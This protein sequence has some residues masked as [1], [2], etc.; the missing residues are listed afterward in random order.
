MTTILSIDPGLI[1]GFAWGKFTETQPYSLTDVVALEFDQISEMLWNS[2][3]PWYDVLVV[4]GFDLTGEV[5]QFLPNLAGLEVIGMIKH[6]MVPTTSEIIWQKRTDKALVPD[7]V[8][9]EN[10]LWQ[11]G[12]TVGWEDGR[13][14]NDAIIHA[15]VYLRRKRHMPTLRRYFQED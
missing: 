8:L 4:E 6:A 5:D 3:E 1:T 2:E 10:G 11:T 12:R 13:D 7:R 14:V 15:L 9:Q